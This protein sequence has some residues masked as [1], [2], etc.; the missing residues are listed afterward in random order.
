MER[1]D[2]A[3]TS[4]KLPWDHARAWLAL[5]KGDLA[6]ARSIAL[7]YR[8]HPVHHWQE[9]FGELLAQLDEVEGRGSERTGDM[10]ERRALE[11]QAAA[12]P[13][14]RL[15]RTDA[16][17][18]AIAGRNV[19]TCTLR[20]RGVD[21][22]SLFSRTPFGL[23]GDGKGL[24]LVAPA[25]EQTVAVGPDGKAT[26][27]IPEAWRSRTAVVE[28]NADGAQARLLLADSD[29]EV[30]VSAG[31]GLVRIRTKDGQPV[32][33][34]YVKVYRRHQGEVAFHKDGSTDRRGLFDYAAVNGQKLPAMERLALFIAAEG[35]GAVVREV[36]PPQE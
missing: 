9:R 23:T 24:E 27:D 11:Q 33:A 17:H 36:E 20:W 12:E 25:L 22:E 31:S 29:L 10:A 6:A 30:S 18:L 1:L 32:A 7:R 26:V 34:A 15:E 8:E 19:T 14:V 4:G 16:Q 21:L 2:P 5:A 3:A 35:H 13:S 28:A